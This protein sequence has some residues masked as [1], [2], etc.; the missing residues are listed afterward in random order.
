[1]KTR[2]IVITAVI[3]SMIL[4]GCSG[5]STLGVRIITPSNVIIS[6]NRDVSSFTAIEFSTFGKVNVIQGDVESLN[7]NGPD[8]LVP[9]ISTMVSNGTLVI[10]TTD[11]ITI[12]AT[13]NA[14][15]VTYTI[16]VKNLTSLV[17]SGAGD[18]Q[19]EALT[20]PNMKIAMSG[21]GSISQNQL[22]TDSLILALSGL[23]GINITGTATQTTID[24]SGAG[25]VNAPDLQVQTASVTI[26][27][28]GSATL[29]VTS[30]LTGSISGAGSVSYYG[31][32][33]TNTNSTGLGKF[34]SLGSK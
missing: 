32:P 22:T 26:S 24:I 12:P 27:G 25:S 30:Q 16:V 13:T 15:V 6:Q 21:A 28:L 11:N 19:I 5:L 23:G 31:N 9:E 14:N 4:A 10:K 17:I 8:N 20:T 2:F 1:M 33:Q 18:V 34:T 29:W 3:L 7:I